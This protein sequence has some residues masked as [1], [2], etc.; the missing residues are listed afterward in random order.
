MQD[1]FTQ[2]SQGVKNDVQAILKWAEIFN[3][4]CELG[5]TVAKHLLL[6]CIEMK[7]LIKSEHTDMQAG[8]YFNA[9]KDTADALVL[10]LGPV[11][12]VAVAINAIDNEA[13]DSYAF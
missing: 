8:K 5:I 4:P 3:E 2:C 13:Y 9:G 12:K 1:E 11:H 10:A 6:H 7:K